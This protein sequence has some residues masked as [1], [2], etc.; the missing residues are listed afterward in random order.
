MSAAVAIAESA[1]A[2]REISAFTDDR[3]N[4]IRT[5]AGSA[6][7]KSAPMM[8]PYT[9]GKYVEFIKQYVADRDT[10]AITDAIEEDPTETPEYQAGY[11]D[12]LSEMRNRIW[13]LF[14]QREEG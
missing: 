10:S 14:D 7:A 8:T 9:T 6:L 13:D 2:Q 1:H 12:A 5:N 11:A 3:E 4:Q